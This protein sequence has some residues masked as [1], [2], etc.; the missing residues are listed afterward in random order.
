[1]NE[2]NKPAP[3]WRLLEPR[4]I[5]T[6]KDEQFSCRF[7]EWRRVEPSLMSWRAGD[8]VVPVRRRMEPD[9]VRAELLA[10]LIELEQRAGL[11]LDL[12]GSHSGAKNRAAL[13]AAQA[14]IARAT[15]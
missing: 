13:Q 4:E 3:V 2:Q 6:E 8:V 5:V 12:T 7:L 9:P 10:A 14:A 1:M 11:W 15:A